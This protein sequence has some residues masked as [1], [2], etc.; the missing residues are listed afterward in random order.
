[1]L[2]HPRLYRRFGF[3]AATARDLR[4]PYSGDA[5]M[6][7]ELKPGI[8]VGSPAVARYAAAFN[9]LPAEDQS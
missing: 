9:A 2:G 8:L 7:L 1:M 4:A 5:F 6:A 3:S